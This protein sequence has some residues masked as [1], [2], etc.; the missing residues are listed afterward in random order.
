MAWIYDLVFLI[1]FAFAA[2]ASWRKGF[3]ASL[4]EL[5][6]AVVGVGVAV[7]ASRSLSV[8]IY[9][10]FVS[11]SV[12]EKVESAVA[13]SGGDLAA[14][15]QAM[16]F[17]PDTVR[18]T[19]AQL[20]Q[21]AGNALPEQITTALEPILLPF[22]QVLLFVVLCMVVRWVFRLLVG[23]LRHVN[24]VPLLGGVNRLLGLVLGL[25]TGALDCWL[26]ALLLW[27]AASVT[28]GLLEFLTLSVLNQ[29]VGYSFFG[30]FNPFLVHY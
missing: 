13:Q 1:V 17:L 5:V 19:L 23:L 28:A 12:S 3:L 25:M 29:S 22:V 9:E 10:Q 7:W 6:G 18:D 15:V 27:F 14:A 2:V 20:V 30:A 24:G 26:L 16:D 4:T 21:G 11:G 8:P